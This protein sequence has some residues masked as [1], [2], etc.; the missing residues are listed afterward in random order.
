[1]LK[2]VNIMA[3]SIRLEVTTANRDELSVTGAQLQKLKEYV[4]EVT[5]A[6]T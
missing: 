1:V 3:E 4:A 6:V 5:Q 2:Q